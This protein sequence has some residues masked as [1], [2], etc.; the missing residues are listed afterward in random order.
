MDPEAGI[1]QVAA[2]GELSCGH[3]S[4]KRS[5]CAVDV[6]HTVSGILLSTAEGLGPQNEKSEVYYDLKSTAVSRGAT[7]NR[8]V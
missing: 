8:T 7:P 2:A 6:D 5:G 4:P 3:P 1:D